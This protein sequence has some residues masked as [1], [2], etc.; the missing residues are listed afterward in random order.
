MASRPVL[1]ALVCAAVLLFPL[2][3]RGVIHAPRSSSHHGG[4][5]EPRTFEISEEG[6]GLRDAFGKAAGHR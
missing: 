1:A 2:G 6:G 5:I 4:L 3:A